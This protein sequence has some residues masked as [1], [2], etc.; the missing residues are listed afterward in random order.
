[1]TAPL[2][3]QLAREL[4]REGCIVEIPV[5]T[6]SMQPLLAPGSTV[7][8]EPAR[9]ADVVPGDVVVVEKNGRL[10]C[11]RLIRKT[12]ASVV[13]RGDA[14]SGDDEPL[15][16]AAVVG[17]VPVAPSPRAVYAAVRALLRF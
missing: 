5:G 1:V 9:A 3:P 4:L 15:P 13:T 10:I 2:R 14:L 11:H 17:R 8:V 12:A 6:G 16:L 7:R